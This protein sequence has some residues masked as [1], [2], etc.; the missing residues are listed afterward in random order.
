M[1]SGRV[2]ASEEIETGRKELPCVHCGLPTIASANDD[3]STL[4]CCNGC[5]Q[6]YEL[7]HGWGLDDFYAIRDQTGSPSSAVNPSETAYDCFDDEAFLGDCVPKPL[8]DGT[9]AT[10]LSVSGLH[11]AACAWLIENVANRTSGWTAARVKLNRHT[12][13][14]IYEPGS[15]KLSEI[16][17]LVGRLGY[18]LA[19]LDG[20][21]DSFARENRRL[22]MQIAVAGFCAANAM[23]IAIALYAGEV[24]ET[25]GAAGVAEEYRFLFRIAG[26]ALGVA[27]VLF[28]GRTLFASALA[29]LRTR[30]PHM[31]LPVALGLSVGTIVGVWS[32]IGNT[33][34]VYFDSLTMLVFFLLIGRWIQFRQQHRAANAVD[35][36]LR[37]TPQHAR[38][39]EHA[40][41]PGR[42][43]LVQSL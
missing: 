41:D 38:L 35:L 16:A 36:L 14:L 17:R 15:I 43:V 11:C 3:P 30:T 40:G 7:I 22:L 2:N 42:L 8:S 34:E 29:A 5:R 27:S 19:P 33:G 37:I 21:D 26:T 6:A 32:A 31:D 1:L 12:L 28:P 4:F 10:E 18:Q 25:A 39:L 13:Q 24:A 20:R 9:V 23:W